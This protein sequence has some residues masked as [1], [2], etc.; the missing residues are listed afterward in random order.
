MSI[1]IFNILNKITTIKPENLM[2]SKFHI[3]YLNNTNY[4]K[5]RK[6][7]LNHITHIGVD[8]ILFKLLVNFFLKKEKIERTS[9]D[10]TSNAPHFFDEIIKKKLRVY[11]IGG[12][13]LEINAFKDL[14]I[15]QNGY[16]KN[17]GFYTGYISCK[18]Y[19]SWDDYLKSIDLSKYDIFILGLGA[20]LQE[21]VGSLIHSFNSKASTITCGGFMSQCVSSDNFQYYPNI[22]NK[23][24]LRWAYR[25]IFEPHVLR[26]FI[27]DYPPSTFIIIYDCIKKILKNG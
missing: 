20:P 3:T 10:F 7:N 8:G 26:R 2:E 21:E 25:I 9:F 6:M 19:A 16:F 27:L 15:A 1:N 11:F 18:G 12:K 17:S 14:M 5:I 4:L 13:L 23:L 22:I 24:N